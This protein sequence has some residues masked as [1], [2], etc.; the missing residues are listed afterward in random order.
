MPGKSD[1][2]YFYYRDLFKGRRLPLA[3]VDL[4]RFDANIAMS[5]IP[6]NIAAKRSGWP[7][8]RSAVRT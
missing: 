4:D 2:D 1:R 5:P 3:F 6:R 7:P 8:N